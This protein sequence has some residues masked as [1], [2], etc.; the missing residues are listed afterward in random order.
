MA[1]DGGGAS[2]ECPNQ[3]WEPPSGPMGTTPLGRWV[4]GGNYPP[5]AGGC[6]IRYRTNSGQLSVMCNIADVHPYWQSRM[7][8]LSEPSA[9]VAAVVALKAKRP[10][11]VLLLFNGRLLAVLVHRGLQLPG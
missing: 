5:D 1:Q 6:C 10:R 9:P 4:F 8:A 2:A 7:P 3:G 11:L